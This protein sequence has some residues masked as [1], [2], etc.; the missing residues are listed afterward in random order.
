VQ[1]KHSGDGGDGCREMP[2]LENGDDSAT[3]QHGERKQKNAL[4][5]FALAH[6]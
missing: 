1:H 5:F 3:K 6:L 4:T 2:W